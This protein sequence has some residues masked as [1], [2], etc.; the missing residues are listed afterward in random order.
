MCLTP[1][2]TGFTTRTATTY[3]PAIDIVDIRLSTYQP[4]EG[5]K[6]EI[7]AVINN[8]GNTTVFIGV[9]FK[10]ENETF[11]EVS[12]DIEANTTEHVTAL[13]TA[14]HGNHIIYI[15][16]GWLTRTITIYVE[17]Y[18]E[19]SE[20]VE[21]LT[22]IG[23]LGGGFAL[24]FAVYLAI[25]VLR[26]DEGTPEMRRIASH[27]REGARAYLK[28]QYTGVAVFVAVMFIIL[29]YLGIQE[30]MSIN[31]SISFLIGGFFSASAGYI[32][33]TLATNAN[34]RTTYACTKNLNSG[35][36]VAFS[37]GAVMGLTVVGLG[38][39]GVSGLYLLFRD[40]SII[41][42]FSMG[43]SSIA[44]FA[45]VGGG[46]YTKGADVGADLVGKVEAGIPEDDPRNPAVIADQVGD[47]VGD[48]AGM[49]ADLY[50][51]Y[52]GALIASMV[53]STTAFV[54][55]GDTLVIKGMA[56]P[57]LI[58]TAGIVASIIGSFLIRAGERAE[59][60]VL[61]F[62]LRRGIFTAAILTGVFSFLIVYYYMGIDYVGLF[63]ATCAGLI[64]GVAIGLFT[65]YFTSD[66]YSPTRTI[67]E[68]SQTGTAT[69]IIS[70][71]STGM[72]STFLPIIA[73]ATAVLAS[74]FLAGGGTNPNLGLYGIG[75]AAV[76]MLSTLGITLASDAYGP[77]A[78]NS[79]GIAEM[80]HQRPA[81]RE[82]TDAL[83]ALGNTTAATGKGFAI[84]SAALTALALIAAYKNSIESLGYHISLSLMDPRIIVGLFIGGMLPFLFCALTMRAVGRA[85]G[86]IVQEVRRQFREIDGLMEGK[87][88]ADYAQA[89]DICTKT[90]QKEMVVPALLAIIAPLT[91]GLMLGVEAE[92]ALL[93]GALVS[94][95]VLAIMMAN[96]GGAWDN[97]KKYIEKGAFG[98]KGSPSHKAAVVGDTVGDPLKDTSGPSLNILLKLMSMVS[99]V[100]ASVIVHMTLFAV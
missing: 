14:V 86:Q 48:V 79:G 49:G 46:I 55:F 98:G 44:L 36:R 58:A 37:G 88:K 22:W 99:L 51:S 91:V 39:V 71:L 30:F 29:L 11:A 1:T 7:I 53:L 100:F 56:L 89:V 64:A 34:S 26:K 59:Q 57:L 80:S 5:D 66:S 61:L 9:R 82:R 33:M 50:E 20:Y 96:A 76:G 40:P 75:L 62:A 13:W 84:G 24:L 93:V 97:A 73:I 15:E 74:Y 81:I 35:L 12:V 77:I 10:C 41:V 78:D 6:I 63:Y 43:A 28:R 65:E 68:S 54:I 92:L 70:G 18:P 72:L 4:K 47:N 25:V 2:V 32:G 31:T 8:T 38:C 27:I 3:S 83:D 16:A 60:R 94:G 87:A 45:R 17:A 90:A 42:G 69:V 67:S 19:R 23:L 85:A 52:V 95:F 21:D